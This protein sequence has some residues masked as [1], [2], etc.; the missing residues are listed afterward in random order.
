MALM[1]E[2]AGIKTC[3][4]NSSPA[5]GAYTAS[6]W[7]CRKKTAASCSSRSCD[8]GVTIYER[9]RKESE[10]DCNESTGLR[11]WQTTP[12]TKRYLV[13]N[14]A[15]HIRQYDKP[16]SG[17]RIAFQWIIDECRTFV[18]PQGWTEGA[19]K[20]AGCHDDFVIFLGIGLA[21]ISSATT[22]VRPHLT[23]RASEEMPHGGLRGNG[24]RN[25]LFVELVNAEQH[26][27]IRLI[28]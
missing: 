22:Y 7:S 21:T 16:G 26:Q 11:G 8:C 27:E 4:P 12:K 13:E 17:L 20:I 15:R 3:L 28:S 25:Y 14:M 18:R 2:I 10:I 24:R 23:G 6:A 19:L 9:E 1:P 5:C